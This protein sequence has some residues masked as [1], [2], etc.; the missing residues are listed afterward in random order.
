VPCVTFCAG[1]PL[2]TI[3]ALI[4]MFRQSAE[5]YV[6]Q[7]SAIQVYLEDEPGRIIDAEAEAKKTRDEREDEAQIKTKQLASFSDFLQGLGLL[8][9]PAQHF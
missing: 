1:T 2:D 7:S 8:L 6:E 5:G 4:R 3:V 9:V